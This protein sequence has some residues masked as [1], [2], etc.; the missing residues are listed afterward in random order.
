MSNKHLFLL[1]G[2]EYRPTPNWHHV[3]FQ[4]SMKQLR[5]RQRQ[6][7]PVHSKIFCRH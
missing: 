4:L 7:S 2:T 6:E 5:E 1:K 3:I